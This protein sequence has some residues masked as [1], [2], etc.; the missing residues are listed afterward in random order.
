[1][2]KEVSEKISEYLT[3]NKINKD[4]LK[5][6]PKNL[7]MSSAEKSSKQKREDKKII[8]KTASKIL[9]EYESKNGKSFFENIFG[10][11]G[12]LFKSIPKRGGRRG[13]R[14]RRGSGDP[15]M[16]AYGDNIDKALLSLIASVE[17][18]N[19]DVFNQS[20]GR[21]PGKASEKT[22]GWLVDNA[23]GAIGRYQHMP[24][25]LL[26]RAEEAGYGRDTVFT[27]EVQDKITLKFLYGSHSYAAWRSG[28][29][30]DE[31][32]GNRLSATWRGLPHSS[33][34][35]Y[36]DQY[37]GRNKAHMGRSAFMLRLAEI[38]GMDPG[39]ISSKPP[40]GEYDIIIPLDHVPSSMSGK[41]PDTDDRKSFN[42]SKMTGAAGREREHQDK[43]AAKLKS[44]LDKKGYR[45]GIIKPETFSSYEAYD[46]YI[47]QQSSKGV[48]ILPLH[49]DAEVGKGG[50]GFLTRTRSGD[51][52]DAALAAPIQQALEHFQKKN[53]NLGNISKDTVSNATVTAGAA[54][55]T[56]LI[57]L[58]AMVQWERQ[59][60]KNFTNTQKF[61]ELIQGIADAVEKTVPKRQ[62]P[63]TKTEKP[64]NRRGAAPRVS[65]TQTQTQTAAKIAKSYEQD[66]DSM[67]I[68]A[69]LAKPQIQPVQKT[70]QQTVQVEESKLE[71][72]KTSASIAMLIIG[73][74][75]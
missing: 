34:G 60:G 56:A 42:Q 22:I 75:A 15:G 17:A 65:S 21:T 59:H 62:K 16:T 37:A 14:G 25:L 5:S 12:D 73:N 28:K 30:S 71:P 61:D 7:L 32:F 18:K 1:V 13:R 39:I 51:A 57:E 38:R 44:K 68:I 6:N 50:T 33:G 63:P 55:P 53:K 8:A 46:K 19:Y 31:E 4:F 64:R 43:A 48:R 40:T 35:T 20:A 29:I 23:Q 47:K 69:S 74:A 41:F 26:G 52:E 49:F 70:S 10:D 27:P 2:E 3:E 66:S 36:P 67:V 24:R 45:V 9:Q 72:S 58:G 54:S 11:I